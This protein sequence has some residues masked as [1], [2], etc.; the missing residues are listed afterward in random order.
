MK[1]SN[2][3]PHEGT[4]VRQMPK[5]TCYSCK[6]YGCTDSIETQCMGYERAG[7]LTMAVRKLLVKE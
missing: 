6:H 4:L 1:N 2:K 5:E 3:L 7:K